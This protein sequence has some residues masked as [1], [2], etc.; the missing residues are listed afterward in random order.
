MS[1]TEKIIYDNLGKKNKEIRDCWL[2][3]T[4]AAVPPGLKLLDAGAGEQ[5]YKKYCSHLKYVSQDFAEYTGVGDNLGLQTGKW[6]TSNLDIISDINSIPVPDSSFDVVL[7]TEVFEH[8]SEPIRTISE[9]SRILKPGGKL[10]LTL[11]VCSL[12]H[13]AP[14]YYYNGFSRYFLQKFLEESS[15]LIGEMTY[16]GN[17]YEYLA[18]ELHRVPYMAE[19][20]SKIKIPFFKIGFKTLMIPLMIFLNYLSKHDSGSSELLSLGIHVVATRE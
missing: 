10:I 2:E 8:I 13:F 5:Q 20:Y 9:F 14:Y 18:Q 7:C 12:T 16:N 6:D 17:Y 3:K 1:K 4:L 15:F 19:R 11:P